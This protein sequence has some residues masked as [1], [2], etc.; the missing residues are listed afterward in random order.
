MTPIMSLEQF[1]K[2]R[3]EIIS[4]MLDN[5]GEHEIYPTG[6]CYYELDQLF[7]RILDSFAEHNK[8]VIAAL[9]HDPLNM[10]YLVK[11]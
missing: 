2:E 6:K 11:D 8:L 10:K 7:C 9:K 3:T 4:R 1:Q 5:P